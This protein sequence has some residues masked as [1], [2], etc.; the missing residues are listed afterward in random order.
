MIESEWLNNP[1]PYVSYT[2]DAD[3]RLVAIIQRHGF[4]FD[5]R[6]WFWIPHSRRGGELRSDLVKRSPLWTYPCKSVPAEKSARRKA[7][8]HFGQRKLVMEVIA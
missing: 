1:G 6:F 5:D 2:Y 3:P 7:M 4:A 8:H